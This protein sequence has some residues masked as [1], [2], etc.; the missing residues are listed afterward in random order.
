MIFSKKIVFPIVTIGSLFFIQNA[1]AAD[2]ILRP[3]LTPQVH[4]ISM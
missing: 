3:S 4:I 1:Q 2:I